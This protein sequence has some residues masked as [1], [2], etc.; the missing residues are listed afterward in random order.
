MTGLPMNKSLLRLTIA[1]MTLATSLSYAAGD[2]IWE[3]K[4]HNE[5]PKA[6]QGDPS[7]QYKVGEMY[8][9]GKGAVKDRAKAFEW[10]SKAAEQGNTKA[11]YKIGY[12]YLK[13][14]GTGKDYEQAHTWLKRAADEGYVRAYFYL[15]EI[16]ENGNGV[17]QDYDQATK[18]YKLALKGGFGMASDRLSRVA[19]A[20]K[21]QEAELAAARK[22]KPKP[23]PKPQVTTAKPTPK[24][25]A[26][27]K[28]RVLA[29]GWKKR[30][31]AVEYLPSTVA[32]CNDKGARIECNSKEVRRNIG[33]ADI[34]YTTRANL[35]SF[36]PDGTFKVSYRNNVTKVVVTDPEFAESGEKP[37][38]TVGWQD[39]EHKLV[40]EFSNDDH[41][42]CT[43][44]KLRKY[45][46]HR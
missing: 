26:T 24:H 44:N 9:K 21:E 1:A 19:E 13:G 6:E 32:D 8:E 35:F 31:K 12:F 16:Y 40:C 2:Y 29:G 27:T 45:K 43:K 5:L 4:F 11:A 22:P 7:S 38:V 14:L 37:P 42:V 3:E 33:V 41:M 17:L 20:Q 18:W 25:V 10:Y 46:L 34:F 28:E 23:R 39:A 30:G 15:G 36:K